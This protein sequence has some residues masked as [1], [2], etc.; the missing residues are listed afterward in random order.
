MTPCVVALAQAERGKVIYVLLHKI[1]S[2][3]CM[4]FLPGTF[5]LLEGG[6][7]QSRIHPQDK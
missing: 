7:S 6:R 1:L 3:P 4:C 2:A 5:N